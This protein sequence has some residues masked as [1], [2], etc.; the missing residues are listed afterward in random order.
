MGP[1]QKIQA[2]AN[3]EHTSGPHD[4]ARPPP[5]G[6]SPC[7]AVSTFSFCLRLYFLFWPRLIFSVWPHIVFSAVC[8]NSFPVVEM[9]FLQDYSFMYIYIYIY[10]STKRANMHCMWP[11]GPYVF[12]TRSP[13]RLSVRKL[14][15][16]CPGRVTSPALHKALDGFKVILMRP[17][18]VQEYIYLAVFFGTSFQFLRFCVLCLCFP[19]P[20]PSK[21]VGDVFKCIGGV[22]CIE[23]AYGNG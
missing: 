8:F 1:K 18:D 3:D 7:G 15:N 13:Y 5:C 20:E 10:F 6:D 19:V 14:R 17:S 4:V 2:E 11:A 23:F 16:V 21:E 12:C 9:G 22:F